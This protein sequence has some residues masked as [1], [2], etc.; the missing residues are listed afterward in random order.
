[1]TTAE[2]SAHTSRTDPW[3]SGN[4]RGPRE[5]RMLTEVTAALPPFIADL[6]YI[7]TRAIATEIERGER[8]IIALDADAGRDVASLNSCSVPSR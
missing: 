2:W 1:M 5:D 8:A 4:S 7:P 3:R 6:D